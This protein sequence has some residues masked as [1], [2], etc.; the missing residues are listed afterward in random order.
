ME[1]INKRQLMKRQKIFANNVSN[2]ELIFKT[3]N[4]FIQLNRRD[5][6]NNQELQPNMFKI[7]QK[8]QINFSPKKTDSQRI[9]EQMPNITSNQRNANQNHN[10]TLPYTC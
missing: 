10:D 4:E 2:K 5:T 3:Y 9:H 6:Q 8:I 1:T 7:G